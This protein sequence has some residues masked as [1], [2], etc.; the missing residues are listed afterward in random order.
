LK[1]HAHTFTFII[2]F[3]T[4]DPEY[5]VFA[6]TR[7]DN[8]MGQDPLDFGDGIVPVASA[9]GPFGDDPATA[10][11]IFL[12]RLDH[13]ELAMDGAVLAKVDGALYNLAGSRVQ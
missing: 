7:L 2:S 11:N 13:F 8:Y 4:P 1:P 9:V 6:G 10:P 5:Y 12:Y 3:Q